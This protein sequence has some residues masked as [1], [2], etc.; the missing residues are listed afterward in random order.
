LLETVRRS[1]VSVSHYP[2]YAIYHV[3]AHDSALY[4][5]GA[6]VIGYDAFTGEGCDFPQAL[7][8]FP[9]WTALTEDPRKYGFHGTLKAPFPLVATARED[10]LIAA[11]EKFSARG[12]P[13]ITPVVDLLGDFIAI[14][15][16]EPVTALSHLADDCVTQFERFRAPLTEAERAR[17][18]KSKLTP[19]QIG[20]VDKYGYP[21]VFEDFRFHMTLTGRLTDSRRDD[22]LAKLREEF[23][24]LRIAE[25]AI[26]AIS[27]FRQP[28]SDKPFEIIARKE[29]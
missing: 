17:R 4:R 25:L 26:D 6:E 20:H 29:L 15:P 7:R 16:K 8:A 1:N 28:A 24:A 9:D 22:I 3:P 2:R 11:V 18:L 21:Y 10:A 23:A 12:V 13:I 14:V 5:F 27:L 19:R